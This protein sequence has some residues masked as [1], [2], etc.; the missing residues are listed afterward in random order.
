M[1]AK[2]YAKVCK[3]CNSHHIKKD[4]MMRGKQRYRCKDCGYV[5]QNKRRSTW[6]KTIV[7]KTLWHEY[8]FGKQTYEQ[9]S[10]KY[11]KTKKTIQKILDTYTFTV[12]HV[13]WSKEVILLIDTT[14]FWD[15][16]IMVFKESTTKKILHVKVVDNEKILY[17]KEWIW[18]LQR[19]WWIIRAIVCDGRKWV[20]WGFGNIPTQMCMF[21]QEKIIT[22]YLTKRPKLEA[23]QSLRRLSLM[24]TKTDKESF[25]SLLEA[26]YARYQDFIQ[27][28]TYSED[29]KRWHYTHKRTR[30][31][32]FSLKNNLK[33]LFIWYDYLWVLSIPNTTNWL[34][35]IFGHIKVKVAL[36]RWL[37][38]ERKIKLILSLLHWFK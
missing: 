17:Y 16:G 29:R 6:H 23:N 19:Q 10:L 37:K 30:S 8:C 31:A 26:W 11:G 21:H 1:W 2:R 22:K 27:E 13:V 32:Y 38:R 35:W 12:E 33:Y 9:L 7:S 28:K 4:G 36:H 20:L 15:F 25:T 18:E 24:L 5:F 3:K 34:E 14:F